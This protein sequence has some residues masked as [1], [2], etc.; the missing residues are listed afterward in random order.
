MSILGKK[1][2]RFIRAG[3]IKPG[4][5]KGKRGF[6]PSARKSIITTRTGIDD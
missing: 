2:T 3:I 6:E 5:V 4:S 1:R